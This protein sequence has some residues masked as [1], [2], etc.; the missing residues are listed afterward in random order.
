MTPWRV[1]PTLRG[2]RRHVFYEEETE[3]KRI[4]AILEV[5]PVD[6]SGQRRNS[7][8]LRVAKALNDGKVV[9]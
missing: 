2:I 9:P 8:A 4:T 7:L 3:E 6:D 1:D 5:G